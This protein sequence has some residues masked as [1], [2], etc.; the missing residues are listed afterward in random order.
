MWLRLAPLTPSTAIDFE[1]STSSGLSVALFTGRSSSD[2]PP[3][4]LTVHQIFCSWRCSLAASSTGVELEPTLEPAASLACRTSRL[5]T[6]TRLIVPE[7]LA[8]GANED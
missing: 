1:L 2:Q 4:F 3:A 5:R 6:T 7:P 8:P